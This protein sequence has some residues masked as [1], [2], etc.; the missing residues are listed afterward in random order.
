[1]NSFTRR[2][3]VVCLCGFLPIFSGTGTNHQSLENI[4]NSK[5]ELQ[6]LA[7]L[8]SVSGPAKLRL[9]RQT[10]H[11]HRQSNEGQFLDR[12]QCS[13][14]YCL[15]TI[16]DAEIAEISRSMWAADQKQKYHL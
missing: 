2:Q 13:N 12:L 3:A 8:T 5:D 4:H 11:Q 6:L 10:L 1:M 16:V 9:C 14:A 7:S 15:L